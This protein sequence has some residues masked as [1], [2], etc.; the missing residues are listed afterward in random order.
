MLY[1]LTSIS[2]PGEW[3]D[4]GY[5][6]IEQPRLRYTLI[7]HQCLMDLLG[8]PSL[9]ALQRSH[10]IWVEES[11]KLEGGARDGKWS[12]SIAVGSK[13]FVAMVKKQL[14]LRAKGRKLTESTHECQL[15]ERQFPY[16]AISGGENGPLSSQNQHFWEIYPSAPDG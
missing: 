5:K 4:W 7:D 16:S 12:E 3:E 9:E 15:R 13:D 6:E 1:H 2:H 11:L 10:R 14:G 8:I